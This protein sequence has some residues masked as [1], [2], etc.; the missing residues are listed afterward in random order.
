LKGH[1]FW[2]KVS[3]NIL[4]VGAWRYLTG[5]NYFFGKKWN[6]KKFKNRKKTCLYRTKL[7]CKVQ[8]I[9]FENMYSKFGQ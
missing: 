7:N 5:R 2:H 8:N 3:V 9:Y 1:N 6:F 4:K